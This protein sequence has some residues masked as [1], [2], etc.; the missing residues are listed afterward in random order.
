MSLFTI[1]HSGEFTVNRSRIGPTGQCIWFPDLPPGLAGRP[2]RMENAA[3]LR[4]SLTHSAAPA[5]ACLELSFHRQRLFSFH[6]CSERAGITATG[7]RM[8]RIPRR[9]S[10]C[11]PAG[12]EAPPARPPAPGCSAACTGRVALLQVMRLWRL[13]ERRNCF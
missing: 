10:G 12:E 11:C 4:F 3:R 2:S 5:A 9:G 6:H 1:F 8:P 13:P 7:P